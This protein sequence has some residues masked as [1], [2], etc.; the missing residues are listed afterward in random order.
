M[1]KVLYI[2]LVSFAIGSCCGIP[3]DARVSE[4]C[5][6]IS[7][8]GKDITIPRN[9]APLNFDIGTEGRCVT[10][11]ENGGESVHLR[12]RNVRIPAG[13]WHNLL[14]AG[15]EVCV[16]VYIKGDDGWT[17]Y[18][19]LEW[20]VADGID[21]YLSYRLIPPSYQS[22]DEIS[23]Q[24]R[25]LTNFREKL[26]YSNALVQ[27]RNSQQCVNCHHFRN[28]RTEEMQFHIRQYLGC[29]VIVGNDGIHRINLKTDSTLSAG[30]YPAWNP[31]YDFIA[32]SVNNTTQRFH[33]ADLNRIEVLD[34]GSDLVLYDVNGRSVS[35][36]GNRPDEL[37]CFPSWAPDGRTLYYVSAHIEVPDS[38]DRAKYIY[39]NYQNIHYDLYSKSFNPDSLI[40]GEPEKIIDAASVGHSIALPRV[41]PNGRYLL[42][43]MAGYGVFH[44]WHR[45]A[46]LYM[47]DLN[48]LSV[49]SLTEI[50]SPEVE[51]YHSW[52]SD[53]QWIVFC[54]RRDDG[55]N[56]RLYI[57]HLE[58]DGSFS[59]PFLLPQRNPAVNS[60]LLKSFSIPE[61]TVEPV[62]ISAHEF[63]SHV[64]KDSLESVSFTS[65]S[66]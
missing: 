40:W 43:S 11:L 26:I 24:Q 58:E 14:K 28:Y 32:Y 8:Y 21:E 65:Q 62:R 17:Q 10:L 51:S 55:N 56:T 22:Y 25:N 54:S 23:L 60:Q 52:S 66:K 64:R 31:K 19:T 7:Y 13:K 38:V 39:D 61:L 29:T 15:S 42:F 34:L 41:S 46:D 53:G 2:L 37:E 45:D 30:V 27:D 36:I 9:I 16:T 5:P 48:S 1:G 47:A 59:E 49:R 20:S 6:P 44:I 3:K 4:D 33:S 57:S 50:N 18:R 63:A 35:F 12:G